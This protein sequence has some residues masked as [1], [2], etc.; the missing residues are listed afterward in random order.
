VPFGPTAIAV[1]PEGGF[2]AEERDAFAVAGW[3][4]AS[5]GATTLRFETAGVAAAAIVRAAQAR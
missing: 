5:L 4:A 3:R 2:E 1:G